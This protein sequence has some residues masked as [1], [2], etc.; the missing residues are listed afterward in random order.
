MPT[1]VP[2]PEQAS[3]AAEPSSAAINPLGAPSATVEAP[4]A[5][6]LVPEPASSS[7][8]PRPTVVHA[9]P[10]DALRLD[11]TELA[12]CAL[13]GAIAYWPVSLPGWLSLDGVT[14]VA[15]GTVPARAAGSRERIA[16]AVANRHGARATLALD[17]IVADAPPVA[18][19]PL[20]AIEAAMRTAA[21]AVPAL[22]ALV[23][24]GREPEARMGDRKQS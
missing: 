6:A 24:A 4:P 9:A 5:T 2:E 3:D 19:D 10:G 7:A 11:V 16:V 23:R 22:R 12:G 1:E 13:V 21:D 15:S 18:V 14:G 8:E 17:L 20:D